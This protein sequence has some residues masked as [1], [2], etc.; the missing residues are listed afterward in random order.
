MFSLELP[1][2]RVAQVGGSIAK[3]GRGK[4]AES[5]GRKPSGA[6]PMM[7]DTGMP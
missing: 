2:T 1:I 3:L 6:D 7:E 4:G 5:S